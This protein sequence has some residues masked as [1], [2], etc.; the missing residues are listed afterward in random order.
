MIRQLLTVQNLIVADGARPIRSAH[1]LAHRVEQRDDLMERLRTRIIKDADAAVGTEQRALVNKKPADILKAI[2]QS[3]H[4]ELGS[5]ADLARLPIQLPD[6]RRG[7]DDLAARL[8]RGRSDQSFGAL[9]DHAAPC[10]SPSGAAQDR[11][12][13]TRK[14]S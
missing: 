9:N 2:R 6:G 4:N 1:G 12:I 10:M 7:Q 8:A 5:L 13:Y 14:L 3:K 11:V